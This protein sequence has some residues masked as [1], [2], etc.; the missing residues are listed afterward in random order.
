MQAVRGVDCGSVLVAGGAGDVSKSMPLMAPPKSAREALRAKAFPV[1]E[2][3]DPYVARSP[4]VSMNGV[5]ECVQRLMKLNEEQRRQMSLNGLE[6]FWKPYI[7]K[8][9]TKSAR[10]LIDMYDMKLHTPRSVEFSAELLPRIY[11]AKYDS[12]VKE[13]LLLMENPCE[14]LLQNGVVV[15]DCPRAMVLTV[16]STSKVCTE[17]HLRVSFDTAHKIQCWEF[18]TRHHEELIVLNPPPPQPVEFTSSSLDRSNHQPTALPEKAVN[19]LGVSS[20]MLRVVRVA[21][22]VYA[23]RQTIAQSLGLEQELSSVDKSKTG[24]KGNVITTTAKSPDALDP[25]SRAAVEAGVEHTITVAS[26]PRDLG[27]G[28]TAVAPPPPPPLARTNSQDDRDPNQ[29]ALS[30]TRDEP[31]NRGRKGR[32]GG[33][34]ARGRQRSAP[35]AAAITVASSQRVPGAGGKGKSVGGRGNAKKRGVSEFELTD[36]GRTYEDAGGVAQSG[37]GQN[38]GRSLLGSKNGGATV[39]G[40]GGDDGDGDFHAEDLVARQPRAEAMNQWL[41]RTSE[42]ETGGGRLGM[43]NEASPEN[44]HVMNSLMDQLR[45]GGDRD[46]MRSALGAYAGRGV[47]EV[48]R[49]SSFP[50]NEALMRGMSNGMVDDLGDLNG[51][52]DDAFGLKRRAGADGADNYRPVAFGRNGRQQLQNASRDNARKDAAPGGAAYEYGEHEH[53]DDEDVEL[54]GAFIIDSNDAAFAS[55]LGGRMLG[56]SLGPTQRTNK[57]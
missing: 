12:G 24:S 22:C 1:A 47:D 44:N 18:S 42:G 54:D 33:A 40:G 34:S 6:E 29:P 57:S 10:V 49:E 23:M 39:D 41:R 45:G 26:S 15:V 20:E 25:D 43:G 27:T 3:R 14:F 53:P 7:D 30:T 51:V 2:E 19:T 5:G 50:M 32:R 17:G 8:Y 55:G 4:I 31:A 21:E 36:E 38:D 56:S 37:G 52:D 11:K 35:G 48:Q 13:E 46:A 9:Y 28:V 16:Y